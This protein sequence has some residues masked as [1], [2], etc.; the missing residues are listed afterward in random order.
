GTG[1]SPEGFA[2]FDGWSQKWPGYNARDTQKAWESFKPKEVGA[3]T[4]FK[5]A[6]EATPDWQD[7]YYPRENGPIPLGFTKDEGSAFGDRVRNLIVIASSGKLLAIQGLL[8]LMPF[9]FWAERYPSTK[10]FN[11]LRAGEALIEACRSAGPFNP[12]QVRGRGI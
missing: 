3:G 10:G 5:L 1:G 7:R 6:D 2:L 11:P 9:K 12:Q 8:G 4:L